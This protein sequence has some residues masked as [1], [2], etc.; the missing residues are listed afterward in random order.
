MA[1]IVPDTPV[2]VPAIRDIVQVIPGTVVLPAIVLRLQPFQVLAIAR[3][4]VLPLQPFLQARAIARMLRVRG[5]P[6]TDPLLFRP[7]GTVRMQARVH[8]PAPTKPAAI[9]VHRPLTLGPCNPIVR[10]RFP[11]PEGGERRV[12]GGTK[13]WQPRVEEE[14][15][16]GA[17]Y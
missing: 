2:I 15:A 10:M 17:N 11:D 8:D 13:V 14:A 16:S 4:I 12:R 3:A 9:N 7:L 6:G 1:A 5:R